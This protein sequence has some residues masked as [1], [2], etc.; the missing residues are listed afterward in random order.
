M[1]T[2]V[3]LAKMILPGLRLL[4]VTGGILWVMPASAGG[5]GPSHY[6]CEITSVYSH[7]P[8]S[9]T[10]GLA[11]AGELLYE[12]S[13]LYGRSALTVRELGGKLIRRKEIPPYLFGEGI[14]VFGDRIIQLCWKAGAG[15]VWDRETLILVRSFSYPT[16]GW[17]ITHDGSRLVMSDGSA[18]LFFLDPLTFSLRKRL[19]VTDGRG[20]VV[21]L[22]ELEYVRGEIWANIWKESRIARIDPENGRVLGWID[23]SEL[24]RRESP[25]DE[26][27]VLNGIAYDPEGDRIFV[28]GKRWSHLYEIRVV[29]SSGG[30]ADHSDLPDQGPP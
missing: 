13:G 22:N 1:H 4:L 12:G 7:D 15:L 24:V 29:E 3:I 26:Q 23:C 27:D 19:T 9:F 17:G 18:S 6:R 20:E 2:S 11:Y 21:R 25:A 14:T 30:P 28:T 10:Q 5:E 16:E 8:Q